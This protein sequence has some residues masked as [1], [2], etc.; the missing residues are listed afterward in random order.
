[1]GRR[2]NDNLVRLFALDSMK[3]KVNLS[4]VFKTKWYEYAVRFVI[5]GSITVAAGLIAD[6]FGPVIGGLF[7][8]FPAI[9]PASATLIEKHERDRKQQAGVQAGRGSRFA[10]VLDAIGAAMGG[11]GMIAFA[12]LVWQL[13]PHHATWLVLTL[14][15]LSWF[16]VSVVSWKIDDAW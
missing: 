13:L 11:I 7:L 12:V 4:A 6:R 1:V 15:V 3:I 8:A 16:T 14:A 10:V 9:F 5:G 2:G